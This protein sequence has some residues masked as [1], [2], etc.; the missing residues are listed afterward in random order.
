MIID[1]GDFKFSS[2]Q[3]AYAYQMASN[4]ELFLKEYYVSDEAVKNLKKAKK[5]AKSS[6]KKILSLLEV[7]DPNPEESHNILGQSQVSGYRLVPGLLENASKF[8]EAKKEIPED[9]N[10]GVAT[11]IQVICKLCHGAGGDSM[12]SSCR[13][14]SDGLL[15]IEVE[16]WDAWGRSQL[17]AQSWP[18]QGVLVDEVLRWERFFHSK[19]GDISLSTLQEVEKFPE[20]G[21]VS[22]QVSNGSFL[23]EQFDPKTSKEGKN[24]DYWLS[25]SPRLTEGEYE[26]LIDSELSC[27]ECEKNS[28]DDEWEQDDCEV[29]EGSGIIV[30]HVPDGIGL[31]SDEEIIKLAIPG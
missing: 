31:R 23:L 6:P 20:R 7:W 14:C 18:L 11:A 25:D 26:F 24:E 30:L 22:Y 21:W 8:Y 1:T 17:K 27:P 28:E 29:C 10:D 4:L 2:E 13:N 9:L 5:I 3:I 12:L 16:E 15:V 19:F